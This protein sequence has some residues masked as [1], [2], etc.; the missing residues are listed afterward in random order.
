MPMTLTLHGAH[1]ITF[2][3][4]ETRPMFVGRLESLNVR[5]G[6]HTQTLPIIFPIMHGLVA[7]GKGIGV[8]KGEYI[9][10]TDCWIEVKHLSV[11]VLRFWVS[12][13]SSLDFILSAVN[14]NDSNIYLMQIQYSEAR[15][16]ECTHAR[17]LTFFQVLH[18][19]YG[20]AM[21]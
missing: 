2:E 20:G 13:F 10:D 18:K 12:Y 3:G 11:L 15:V 19:L 4:D 21:L 9:L 17:L 16:T 14:G 5:A 7:A 8:G 6:A 1:F